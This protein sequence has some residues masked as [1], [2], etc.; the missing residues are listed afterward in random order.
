MF[1]NAVLKQRSEPV[2]DPGARL[3]AVAVSAAQIEAALRVIST[4]PPADVRNPFVQAAALQEYARA[5]TPGCDLLFAT[6]L[7]AR[8]TA[9][10]KSPAASDPGRQSDAESVLEATA[11]FPL[12]ELP[13]GIGFEPC[14][15]Q[16]MILFIKELP[17]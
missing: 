16:E 6:A 2:G 7:H 14:G 13:E 4:L 11:R 17:W 10:A 1:P 12:S 3:N 5:C 9:L 15:F 8:V